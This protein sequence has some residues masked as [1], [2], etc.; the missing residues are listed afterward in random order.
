MSTIP[1][2]LIRKI[3]AATFLLIIL[4]IVTKTLTPYVSG[5]LS[6]VF[7]TAVHT[8]RLVFL[9]FIVFGISGGT[10]LLHKWRSGF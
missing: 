9:L 10:V 8:G 4:N 1:N 5:P 2:N 6:S 3:L 7:W